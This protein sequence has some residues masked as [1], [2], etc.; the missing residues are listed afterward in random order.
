MPYRAAI[1]SAPKS[2]LTPAALGVARAGMKRSRTKSE[3]SKSMDSG[4]HS[5]QDSRVA[6][7]SDDDSDSNI[8][9]PASTNDMRASKRRKK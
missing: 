7:T 6:F 8:E 9:S 5:Q 3:G 4:D 1:A 2:S